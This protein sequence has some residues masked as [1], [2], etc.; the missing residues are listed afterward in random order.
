MTQK[1]TI[2]RQWLDTEFRDAVKDDER[3]FKAAAV[4]KV[5]VEKGDTPVEIVRRVI[6]SFVIDLIDPGSLKRPDRN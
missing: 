6:A 5:G 2:L 3:V 1:E 4:M